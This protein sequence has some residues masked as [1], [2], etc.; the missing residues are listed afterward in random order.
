MKAHPL[1][2][3]RANR[4]TTSSKGTYQTVDLSN[5]KTFLPVYD[6]DRGSFVAAYKKTNDLA[7]KWVVNWQEARERDYI[8]QHT[9]NDL[10]EAFEAFRSSYQLLSV[11][12]LKK[13]HF[14]PVSSI[15]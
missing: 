5:V 13:G 15:S 12:L 6:R 14:I 1:V 7:L 3:C 11:A 8:D 10:K 2:I 4:E 9:A